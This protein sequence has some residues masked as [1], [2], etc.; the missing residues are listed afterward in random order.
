VLNFSFVGSAPMA[1]SP[2]PRVVSWKIFEAI[3]TRCVVP[4]RTWRSGCPGRRRRAGGVVELVFLEDARPE[5][6][7]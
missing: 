1:S 2:A 3:R 5:F 7:A 4:T 6:H